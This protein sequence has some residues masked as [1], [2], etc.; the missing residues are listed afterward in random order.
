MEKIKVLCVEDDRIVVEKWKEHFSSNEKLTLL[1][2]EDLEQAER[3]IKE[4][5]DIKIA[6]LDG[7]VPEFLGSSTLA[8]TPGLIR[9]LQNVNAD[10][11]SASGTPE[12]N[13]FAARSYNIQHPCDDKRLLPE[14]IEEV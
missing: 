1:I 4:N 3:L 7:N 2:A 14:K 12:F 8:S 5:P 10:I 6:T 11:I 13:R 9:L